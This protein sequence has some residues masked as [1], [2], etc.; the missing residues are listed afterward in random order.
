MDGVLLSRIQ[1][2]ITIG[3]HYIFPPL[4]IG[5]SWLVVYFLAKYKKDGSL[6]HAGL[7]KFWTRLL[8]ITF[9]V[10]VA[11]GIAM[12]FQFGTNWANYSRFVGD[13]FG[14]PL[15]AEGIFAFFLESI[16]ISVLIFGWKK[17]SRKTLFFASIMVAIGAILSAFWIIVANSW[18]QTPDGFH[19]VNGRAELTSFASAVFN[20][21]TLPRF[22]HTICGA[23]ITGGM[24]VMGLA[25]WFLLKSRHIEF[26]KASFRPALIIT[27]IA[28]L[29][30]L[31][32]GHYHAIQ[33]AF[34][35]PEKL[36]IFEGLEKT[37]TEAPA[38]IF[39]I[40]DDETRTMK[41]PIKVPGLLS[42]LAFGNLDKEVK[43]IDA[44]APE[45]LPPFSLTF[46]SF[47]AM[48][49]LG[50]YFIGFSLLGLLLLWKKKLYFNK[51]YMRLAILSIPLPFVANE[52]GW[53]AAEVGRQPWAIYHVL[54]TND[55][56]SLSVAPSHILFSIITFS[57]IYAFLFILWIY[58]I[59]N[60]LLKG[61]N[62]E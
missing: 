22:L 19:I 20:P 32:L 41:F 27:V 59:R 14:A 33:V 47:H 30:Q 13:I 17:V 60:Q 52:V 50:L 8:T 39:G 54:K 21:S 25:G 6:F 24:F 29:A 43:G 53:M 18:M 51:F 1:F 44:F 40:P 28:S 3:F 2:A 5:L 11:T 34:T 61:L 16:F 57:I 9:A 12:E 35:Q 38:L 15:A 62:G 37:Q 7:A 58:L 56:I 46:Y 10:G 23:A 49:G 4:S 48:V 45:D 42:L 55:A 31:G 26:A 36:A